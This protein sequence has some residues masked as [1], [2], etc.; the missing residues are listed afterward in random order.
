MSRRLH[1]PSAHARAWGPRG[2]A[3]PSLPQH[4]APRRRRA[5]APLFHSNAE[6][7]RAAGGASTAA[8]RAAGSPGALQRPYLR[9]QR[10]APHG[11]PG[12]ALCPGFRAPP[13]CHAARLLSSSPSRAKRAAGTSYC[14]DVVWVH[15]THMFPARAPSKWRPSLKKR[16]ARSAALFGCN[17]SL[18]LTTP[19]PGAT[20]RR[21]AGRP[22]APARQ[23]PAPPPA[24]APR[25]CSHPSPRA[26]RCARGRGAPGAH[27]WA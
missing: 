13:G 12:V 15:T 22:E 3:R 17:P 27:C 14:H 23:K 7:R 9:G 24:A 8:L 20:A 26:A 2:A 5:P 1:D 16:G 4:L 19:A 21:A 18:S 11:A 25:A 10:G 6:R